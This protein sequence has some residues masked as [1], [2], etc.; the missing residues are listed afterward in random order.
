MLIQFI[1]HICIPYIRIAG[2]F[3]GIQFSWKGHLQ[4]FCDLFFAYKRS[5]IERLHLSFLFCR[6]ILVVCQSTVKAA[7]IRSLENLN[8]ELTLLTSSKKSSL[9]ICLMHDC[10]HNAIHTRSSNVTTFVQ[11]PLYVLI[12]NYLSYNMKVR[13]NKKIKGAPSLKLYYIQNS[14]YIYVMKPQNIIIHTFFQD[15]ETVSQPLI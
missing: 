15:K 8:T 2:N 6:I 4:R 5:S 11:Q 14:Q 13:Q 12:N 9:S 3:R 7:I 1:L 10:V